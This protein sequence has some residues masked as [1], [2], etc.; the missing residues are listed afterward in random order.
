M[1]E[2]MIEDMKVFFFDIKN[3]KKIFFFFFLFQSNLGSMTEKV[4][5][6]I[7]RRATKSGKVL[8]H[9]ELEGMAKRS[10]LLKIKKKSK[11]NF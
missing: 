9:K 2:K 6:A 1:E 5:T 7:I 3:I 4:V 10:G 11:L 8:Y